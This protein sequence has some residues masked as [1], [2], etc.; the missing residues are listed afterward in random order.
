MRE[1]ETVCV[2]KGRTPDKDMEDLGVRL[3]KII[4]DHKGELLA[5][6]FLGK[7]GLASGP[8]VSK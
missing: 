7:K 4:K 1:Y 8:Q 5:K 3:L 2:F 6:R